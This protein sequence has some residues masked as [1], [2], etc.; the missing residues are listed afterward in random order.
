MHC[1][2]RH[3]LHKSL[4]RMSTSVSLKY[5]VYIMFGSLPILPLPAPFA[6]GNLGPLPKSQ[7]FGERTSNEEQNKSNSTS[8][9]VPATVATHTRTIGIIHPP[10]DMRTIVDKTSQFV[11]KNG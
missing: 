3:P 9:L 6:D 1:G 2:C 10:P 4:K 7:V 11:A 5:V 8:V